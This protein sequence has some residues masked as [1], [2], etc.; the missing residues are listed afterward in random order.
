MHR[1]PLSARKETMSSKEKVKNWLLE[2]PRHLTIWLFSVAAAIVVL[3]LV[4]LLVV[5]PR[6]AAIPNRASLLTEGA[7]A[8]KQTDSRLLATVSGKNFH[9]SSTLNLKVSE[10]GRA[11]C[12]ERV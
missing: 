5:A 6:I 9:N 2:T 10:I 7:P 4:V 3:I 1:S 8:E 12:R 11:S